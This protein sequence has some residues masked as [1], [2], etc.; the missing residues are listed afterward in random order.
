MTVD[1]CRDMRP[2]LGAHALGGLEPAEDVALQAH[3]EGCA[4]CRAELRDLQAVARALPLAEVERL[5]PR[6]E[7]ARE[8]VSRVLERLARERDARHRQRVRRALMGA[9]AVAAMVVMVVAL[10]VTINEPRR[11]GTRVALE[12]SGVTAE[13]TLRAKPAGTE[14]ELRGDGFQPGEAY[15]LWLTGDDGDRVTAGTFRGTAR[16]VDVVMTAA[17]PLRDA[18]RIWVTDENDGIVVDEALPERRAGRS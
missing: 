11:G 13:A 18:R 3:L 16:D 2:L 12:G 6:P 10:V 14:V 4:A 7:P 5:D 1:P 9:A 8:L 17:I 15:W